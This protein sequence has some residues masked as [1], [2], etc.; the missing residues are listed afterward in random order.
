MLKVF[1][2]GVLVGWLVEWLIDWLWWRRDGPPATGAGVDARA[3][4]A[5]VP[6]G[7]PRAAGGH[8]AEAGQAAAGGHAAAG[9]QAGADG[10]AV[11][12]DTS[13]GT[14]AGDIATGAPGAVSTSSATLTTHA[15]V[16]RQVDLEAIPGLAPRV[17]AMLRHHGIATFA[18][19]AA[20]PDADLARIVA[21]A[22]DDAAPADTGHWRARARRAVAG[23]WAGFANG[24]ASD[25]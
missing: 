1:V 25:A 7:M 6:A 8:A 4:G 11:S 13:A 12:A 2:L 9:G 21:S 17:A 15:P 16:Y 23:D 18:Q 24:G 10:P 20:A 3:A 5:T 22:G 19:L 14:V